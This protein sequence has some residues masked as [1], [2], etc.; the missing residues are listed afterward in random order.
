M[1]WFGIRGIGSLYYLGYSLR[2]GLEGALAT[3]I[4]GLTISRQR[5]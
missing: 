2:H 4:V 3:E 5:S 1:A